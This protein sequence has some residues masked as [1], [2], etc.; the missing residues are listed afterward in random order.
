MK[1]TILS[2]LLI[3][4]AFATSLT[5]P[6]KNDDNNIQDFPSICL[7]QGACFKGSWINTILGGGSGAFASFQGIR[8]AKPPL[9]SLR[10]KSPEPY[11]YDEGIYDVSQESTISCFAT[12][13]MSDDYETILGQEDCLVINVYIPKHPVFDDNSLNTS[14][15]VMVYIHGGGLTES[16]NN[17]NEYG[18]QYFMEKK[19]VL[20]VINYRLG[21]FGFLSM[22]TSDVPGN[23]GFRDQTLVSR[24]IETILKFE[25]KN[26]TT[27]NLLTYILKNYFPRQ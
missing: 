6:T 10:F 4:F 22:G 24:S 5:N 17:Y 27:F 19:V 26:Y 11:V 14:L 23:A 20:V 16:N 21:P 1:L 15:P 25:I 8:Y 3:T 9:G 7:D 12:G 18:P 2:I 13:P